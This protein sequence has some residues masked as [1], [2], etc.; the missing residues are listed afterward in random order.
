MLR[1]IAE[2]SDS[3]A[4]T[5]PA[6]IAAITAATVSARRSPRACSHCS[7][8]GREPGKLDLIFQRGRASRGQQQELAK[9]SGVDQANISRMISGQQVPS[10]KTIILVA[11]ALGVSESRLIHFPPIWH[12]LTQ[13]IEGDQN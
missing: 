10:L 7:G 13:E 3:N 1:S 5:D 8:S 9:R 2:M 11:R 4:S 12:R 6:D